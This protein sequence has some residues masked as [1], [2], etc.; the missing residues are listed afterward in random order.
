MY[1]KSANSI[2]HFTL[3]RTC[4]GKVDECMSDREMFRAKDL[5]ER[6]ET[7]LLHVLRVMVTM[8]QER[9]RE[10]DTVAVTHAHW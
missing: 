5:A 7:K 2:A 8:K 10:S 1:L 3:R 6:N 4:G 9:E